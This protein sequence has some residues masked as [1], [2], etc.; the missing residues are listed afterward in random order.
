MYPKS[1]QN[2]HHSLK[3]LA[4]VMLAALAIQAQFLCVCKRILDM[5]GGAIRVDS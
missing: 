4:F 3:S 2:S 5:L 1:N